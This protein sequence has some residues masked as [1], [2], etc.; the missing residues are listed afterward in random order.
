MFISLDRMFTSPYLF[1]YCV[2]EGEKMGFITHQLPQHIKYLSRA[3]NLIIFYIY[4]KSTNIT[5]AETREV[6]RSILQF[7]VNPKIFY[8]WNKIK[9]I[10]LP[11]TLPKDK[12]YFAYKLSKFDQNLY[13]PSLHIWV[14]WDVSAR[15]MSSSR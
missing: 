11:F 10:Y 5:N 6:I 8:T 4:L 7:Y 13:F 9:T 15:N 3:N 2:R 14:S 12:N 1:F